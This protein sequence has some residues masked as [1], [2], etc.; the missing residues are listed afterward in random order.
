MSA[1]R[2]IIR[3]SLALG[4]AILSLSTSA[5]S[6]PLC[7]NPLPAIA[8][9]RQ[10]CA[11]LPIGS[12]CYGSAP[13]SAQ[14]WAGLSAPQAF[15]QVGAQLPAPY[16]QSLT[17]NLN[18]QSYGIAILRV[19]LYAE[20]P[21]TPNGANDHLNTGAWQYVDASF[22]L[23]G[24]SQ[25]QNPAPFASA[26]ASAYLR[27]PVRLRA[28][29][30]QGTN[31]R[32]APRED[33]PL[34]TSLIT[35]TEVLALG[36]SNDGAWLLIAYSALNS[37][38]SRVGWVRAEA[39]QT[40]PTG[41]ASVSDEQALYLAPFQQVDSAPVPAPACQ[42]SLPSGILFQTNSDTLPTRLQV[43]DA[44]LRV[45]GQSTLFIQSLAMP[46][47]DDYRQALYVLEGSLRLE[48]ANAEQ[49]ILSAGEWLL[50]PSPEESLPA[51]APYDN[52]LAYLPIEL[53]PRAF[54][55]KVNTTPYIT[56]YDNSGRSPLDG[57]LLSE[58]CRITTGGEGLRLRAGAGLEFP[59][60]G[61]MNFR[62]SAQPIGRAI[63]TDGDNWWQ[64]AAFVWV[65]GGLVVTGGDCASVP[66]SESPAPR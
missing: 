7:A 51:S 28:E 15:E 55:V 29:L 59:V 20:A 35:G 25:L 10:A 49:R 52:S 58:P 66:L 44:S 24:A 22:V 40:S 23:L 50:I 34:L 31:V 43:K 30:A 65:K 4:M 16:L 14:V 32:R 37:A 61:Q 18:E 41:L 19:P 46:E 8:Q 21:E 39:F 42:A 38:Q 57:R 60:M 47:G 27:T 62:E 64:I 2:Q 63:G 48:R 1:F 3:V 56:P 13:L 33:A 26:D 11:D 9:A 45:E 17:S 36:Q 53:L 6:L 5:Q 12:I 54:F